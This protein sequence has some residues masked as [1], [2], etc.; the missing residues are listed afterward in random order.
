MHSENESGS[1]FYQKILKTIILKELVVKACSTGTV[2]VVVII[3][4]LQCM[5]GYN[6]NEGLMILII[7]CTHSLLAARKRKKS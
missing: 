7:Y 4:I 5:A 1:N 3:V 2:I 6:H